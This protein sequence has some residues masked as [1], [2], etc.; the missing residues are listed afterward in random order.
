MLTPV[1]RLP[2]YCRTSGESSSRRAL[3]ANSDSSAHGNVLPRYG[4]SAR[5]DS[6][7]V[8]LCRA[9]GSPR[10]AVGRPRRGPVREERLAH[11]C[12]VHSQRF[13][14]GSDV[15]RLR[16]TRTWTR[17]GLTRIHLSV[18]LWIISAAQCRRNL[19]PVGPFWGINYS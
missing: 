6:G 3:H 1:P 16:T 7:H 5:T 12:G 4:R 11:G 9:I 2:L 17:Y 15:S 19:T 18:S 8:R 13:D 14:P 10:G